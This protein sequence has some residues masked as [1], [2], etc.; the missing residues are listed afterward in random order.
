MSKSKRPDAATVWASEQRTEF[1]VT[2]QHKEEKFP[3]KGHVKRR[4]AMLEVKHLLLKLKRKGYKIEILAGL[5]ELVPV[6]KALE[7]VEG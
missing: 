5:D 4:A 6:F 1:T 7:P 2:R 3:F